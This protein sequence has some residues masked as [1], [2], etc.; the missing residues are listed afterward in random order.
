VSFYILSFSAGGSVS[1]LE[2]R[3]TVSNLETRF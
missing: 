1:I 2:T 3:I